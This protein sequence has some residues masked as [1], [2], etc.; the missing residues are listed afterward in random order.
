MLVSVSHADVD[1][2]GSTMRID[3]ATPAVPGRYPGLVLFADIFGNGTEPSMRALRRF[4]GYGY[5]VAMPQFYHRHQAPDR[6]FPFEDRDGATNASLATQV[7]DFDIDTRATI[8]YLKKR[9]DVRAQALGATGFCIGGHL[10][11]R[12]ALQPEIHA[13]AA[14]YP[15][16]LPQRTLGGSRDVDTLARITAGGIKGATFLALGLIDTH[17]DRDAIAAIYAG[18]AQSPAPFFVSMYDGAHAFMRDN[19]EPRYNPSEAD[20]AYRDA[21][22]F[23]RDR[24]AA[25]G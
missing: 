12:A 9:P 21:L 2:G 25:L 16:G 1:A 18:F 3:V 17:V 6:F 15:T 7:G 13:T 4:A 5:V 10:A 24:L 19:D 22:D 11:V 8:D 14:F 23:L 20:R